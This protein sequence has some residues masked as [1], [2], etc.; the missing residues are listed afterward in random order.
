MEFLRNINLLELLN[1]KS[2]FLFGPRSTGKTHLIRQQLAD[3]A[4]V[5]DLLNSNL[6]LSLN[7]HPSELEGIIDAEL[8]NRSFVVIDEIQKVPLLLNEVHRLIETR[9]LRFLL[10][11]SSARQ[12]KH[13]ESNLLGGR[14]WRAELFPL[15]WSEIPHFQ[16]DHYLRFGGLP[17]VYPSEHPAEELDA[18]V[19]LYLKEEIQAEG[20]VRKLPPFSR[21]L[22]TAALSNGHVLNFTEVA[23]DSQVPPSTVR[24]YYSILTDTLMGFM[25]ESWTASLKR[26]AIQTAKFYFFDTGVMHTLAGT[27]SL[28]RNS[29]LYGAS[30]EQFIGM[31][32]KAYLSYRRIKDSL[33]FWRTTHGFEVDYL[34]GDHSA[35]E[36]KATTKVASKHAKGLQ[37]LAEEN[38]LKKMFL[39]THDRI[40]TKKAGIH[41]LHWESFLKELWE[42]KIVS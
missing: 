37:A 35:V 33:T 21:F 30:F 9:S 8:K 29:D 32:L 25:L 7:A 14:A 12:L 26:K 15:S 6:Y 27:R 10:T 39:V 18:Y 22:K 1:K 34:I 28:D 24:E 16:L 36:V 40:A 4:L 5:I 38:K 17:H 31:E 13:K 2:F 11:G 20:L 3:R 19:N 41:A 42:G 23:S